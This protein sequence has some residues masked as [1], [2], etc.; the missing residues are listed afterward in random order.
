MDYSAGA[1]IGAGLVATAVMTVLLYMGIAMMPKQMTMNLLYILGTMITR[2]KW[3]AY[4]IGT[5]MHVAMGIMFAFIHTGIYQAIGLQS[6]LAGWGILFGLFHWMLVGMGMMGSMHPL[7][8][9]GDLDAP[10]FF[11]KNYPRMTT[12][13]FLMLHLIY[14]ACWL[15][16]CTKLG[17]RT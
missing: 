1:A 16:S 7:M 6:G 5:M 4:L 10:G 12:M 13:G 3:P 8:K 2:N 9:S 14:M 11:V 15:A 17:H